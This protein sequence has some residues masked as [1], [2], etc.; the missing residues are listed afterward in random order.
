[1][2]KI[3]VTGA[4]GFVGKY[5]VRDLA[6]AGHEVV[7]VYR[8]A[9]PDS[10]LGSL[11]G[12]E[13]VQCDLRGSLQGLPPV[14]FVV[15]SATVHPLLN[16]APDAAGFLESN[17]NATHRLAQWA[18]KVGVAKFVYFSTV[19]VHGKVEAGELV[20][21]TPQIAPDLYGISKYL[22]ERVLEGFGEEMEVSV[23]RLPG[24]VGPGLVALGRPWLS[25]VLAK[26]FAG[27]NISIY[28]G[29]SLFNNLIDPTEIARA[30]AAVF[31]RPANGGGLFN[32]AASE[33]APLCEVV[34]RVVRAAGSDSDIV[35]MP[36]DAN[37]F[38]IS[39]AKIEKA[40][41]F[42]ASATMEIVDRFVCG[43]K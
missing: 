43:N 27:E 8:S 10:A 3:L 22:A 9:L 21:E 17:V 16:P 6:E 5:L 36:T 38:F 12:E 24:V 35:D 4:G 20:E 13:W 29:D 31:D 40:M 32:V 42:R 30:C 25:G 26:A 28:N 39:T 41:G 33:P 1:L 23:L 15:H 18:A 11:E 37:S 14:D 2:P 19:T 7:A 34:G